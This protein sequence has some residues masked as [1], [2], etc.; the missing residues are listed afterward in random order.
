MRTLLLALTVFCLASPASGQDVP[1]VERGDR[2]VGASAGYSW[3]SPAGGRWGLITGRRVYLASV[4]G[5]WVHASAGSFAIASS[6][7][8]PVSIVQRTKAESSECWPHP[9]PRWVNC[10]N[11][12]SSH[13]AIGIGGMP[14]LKLLFNRTG[15]TRIF[16][17][18][19]AGLTLFN[20]EVPVRHAG[21][22]NFALEYGTGV[23]LST[24]R[25]RVLTLGYKFYH[26]S[27]GSLR[28]YNPGLDANVLYLGLLR[29]R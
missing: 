20:N 28:D 15:R 27:N 8:V 16:A 12:L 24:S 13:V 6:I 14:G 1:T 25:N 4:R 22:L 11:D 17:A 10:R 9:D 19:A 18:G 3:Y 2:F 5:E 23:E 21:R 26:V 29:R 7:D